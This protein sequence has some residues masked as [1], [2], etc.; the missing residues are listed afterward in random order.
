MAGSCAKPDTGS[1]GAP[2]HTIPHVLGTTPVNVKSGVTEGVVRVARLAVPMIQCRPVPW[3][4]TLPPGP[5]GGGSVSSTTNAPLHEN[6]VSRVFPT[7]FWNPRSMRISTNSTLGSAVIPDIAS[8]MCA[9]WNIASERAGVR[10]ARKRTTRPASV[11]SGRLLFVTGET[12]EAV[13]PLQFRCQYG[14]SVW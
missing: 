1:T 5:V 14:R 8:L 12:V 6:A 3:F 13:A 2:Q 11:R 9:M 10:T 7:A 4:G